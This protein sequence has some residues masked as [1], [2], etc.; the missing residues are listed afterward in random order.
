[1]TPLSKD[2][3][4]VAYDAVKN[5]PSDRLGTAG[6]VASAT[7]GAAGGSAAAGSIASVCGATT[8]FGST[9][10]ASLLGGIV[11]TTTPVGWVAG[12]VGLGV[13]LGLGAAQLIRSGTRADSQRRQVLKDLRDK[14]ERAEETPRTR[15]RASCAS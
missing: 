3:Y 5:A 15:S 4:E 6:I 10:L 8:L 2:E 9:S 1:M 12:S 11:V 13:A 14:I 7:L